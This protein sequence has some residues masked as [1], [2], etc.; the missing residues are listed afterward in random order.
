M[1]SENFFIVFLA[2]SVWLWSLRFEKSPS[3]ELTKGR[4]SDSGFGLFRGV[5]PGEP[6]GAPKVPKQVEN[7]IKKSINSKDF[8]YMFPHILQAQKYPPI[9]IYIPP[10]GRAHLGSVL[11]LLVFPGFLPPDPPGWASLA[12]PSGNLDRKVPHFG[13]EQ[14]GS[15]LECPKSGP[16]SRFLEF[17]IRIWPGFLNFCRFLTQI[18]KSSQLFY[19][20]FCV[21]HIFFRKF[22]CF[23]HFFIDFL[24][25]CM[26]V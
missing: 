21:S 18:S 2:Q 24:I 8:S 14:S 13:A 10:L 15:G 20:N 6:G 7:G 1:F 26:C 11:S 23:P 4:G 17:C 19:G 12:L 22:L 3:P 5:S 9:H 25:P 16:V